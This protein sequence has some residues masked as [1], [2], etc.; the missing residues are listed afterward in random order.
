ML[1]A[2]FRN[3]LTYA[4]NDELRARPDT[5]PT[6]VQRQAF[7]LSLQ[8]LTLPYTQ[9]KA[10]LVSKPAGLTMSP[11]EGLHPRW[12]KTLQNAMNFLDE[13]FKKLDMRAA[14]LALNATRDATTQGPASQRWNDWSG[15]ALQNF[16]DAVQA[17]GVLVTQATRAAPV[18]TKAPM[19]FLALA[20]SANMQ[21]PKMLAG[22]LQGLD[23]LT[24]GGLATVLITAGIAGLGWWY[25][26][27]T[28]G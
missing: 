8:K 4:L 16:Y 22:E 7:Q 3:E 19:P 12:Q 6:G 26:K 27:K 14:V 24:V 21:P 15:N 9:K 18:P 1:A 11:F 20:K 13:A 17:F 28:V 23:E 10:L 5:T 25:A 2:D